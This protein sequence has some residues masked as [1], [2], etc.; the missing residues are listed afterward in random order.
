MAD[1][2]FGVDVLFGSDR[3]T[4]AKVADAQRAMI[5]LDEH[6]EEH[7]HRPPQRIRESVCFPT[8]QEER[9]LR[10]AVKHIASALGVPQAD[11]RSVHLTPHVLTASA[12]GDD[13]RR[14]FVAGR[15]LR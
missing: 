15:V 2:G 14:T 12:V 13:G 4:P 6:G 3:A 11:L 1:D 9:A 10:L 8:E 7:D 5:E